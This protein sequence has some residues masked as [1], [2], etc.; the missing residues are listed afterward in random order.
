MNRSYTVRALISL[1][2][3]AL[4]I[5]GC[6]GGGGGNPAPNPPTITITTL[7]NGVTNQAY[8]Q[9]LTA[10]GG[11]GQLTWSLASGTLPAGLSLSSGGAIT[12]TPTTVGTSNFTVRA[13][14]TASQS[15]TQALSIQITAAPVAISVTTSA[16]SSATVNRPYFVTLSATGGTAPLSWSITSGS[17]PAG[18][19]IASNG[20]ISG[21]P[22]A[23]GASNFTVR[24][25]DS[26]SGSG[27]RD[28]SLSIVA[29]GTLARN[30]NIANAT[31][32]SN[33]TF[34]AS[35]SPMV[36]P[37]GAA[38]I[39]PDQDFYRVTVPAGGTA[40][41]E[42][43]ADRLSPI[44]P[45]DSVLEIVNSSGIRLSTCRST[46]SG[47]FTQSCM[48]DDSDVDFTTLDSRIEFQNS[49]ASAVTVFLH[50]LDFTNNARPDMRYRL[51]ISGVQ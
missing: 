22:T 23:T 48:N 28:L 39:N 40:I 47:A 11:S 4:M 16:L 33:G 5:A 26:A 35:I 46:T 31:T 9:Q 37:S 49:G 27:T 42:I 43:F 1:A 7:P 50:I 29:A 25:Q 41:L 21:T 44:S 13:T 6:G 34:Q 2:A 45:L 8:N 36:D 17:L 51:R 24:V 3:T 30:E 32:L 14:D 20:D 19:S 38:S 15:A 12:G 10:S 18:L